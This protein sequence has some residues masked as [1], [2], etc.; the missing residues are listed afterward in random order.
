MSFSIDTTR[1]LLPGLLGALL[2]AGAVAIWAADGSVHSAESNGAPRDPEP[3]PVR[4]GGVARVDATREVRFSGITRAANRARFSFLVGGR[5]AERP[6]D[7]GDAVRR[8]DVLARL[9]D[10]EYRHHEASARAELARLDARLAQARRDL[11]R[12]RSLA[13]EGAATAEEVE[14]ATSSLDA[15]T[16]ARDAAKARLDEAARQLDETTL[17]APFAATIREAH[18]EPGELV[19]AGEPIVALDARGAVELRVELPESHLR[20]VAT[21]QRVTVEL[22]LAGARRVR[23]RVTSVG[24]SAEGAGQLFPVE[25]ALDA[26]PGIVPGLTA[27]LVLELRDADALAVPL[28]AVV[29][30]GGRAPSIFV[31]RGERAQRVPVTIAALVDD[32]VAVRGALAV[33]EAVVVEGHT[34]LRDGER[35]EVIR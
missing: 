28:R 31:V 8:G 1:R 15:L 30:P 23:G 25:I 26:A 18:A 7:I 29:D 21:G 4:A 32:R 19:S 3:R 27:V 33:G 10:R 22:P 12:S 17:R 5:L 14:R 6:A 2:V 16:A 11:V 9:D 20:H 35:V 24:A 13:S 34:A